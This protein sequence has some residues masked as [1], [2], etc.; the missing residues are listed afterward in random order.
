M[1]RVGKDR[2]AEA[3]ARPGAGPMNITGKPMS[4]FVWVDAKQAD[5]TQLRSL[6]AL[7]SAYVSC[8]LT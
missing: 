8:C 2:E 6:I 3:L 1:F 4:G 7:A 5:E